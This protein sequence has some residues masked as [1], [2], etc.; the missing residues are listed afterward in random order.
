MGG[1]KAKHLDW[2]LEVGPNNAY[3]EMGSFWGTFGK[4]LGGVET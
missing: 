1:I 3:E 4:F 2:K